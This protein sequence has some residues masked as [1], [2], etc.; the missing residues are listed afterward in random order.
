MK[1][2][3]KIICL[4][5]KNK[6]ISVVIPIFNC[7]DSILFVIRSIQNQ[8]MFEIEIILV[9]DHS[10]DDSL[11]IIRNIQKEDNRIIIINNKKNKG[12]FYSRSIGVLESKGEYI[13]PLDND[14][15]VFDR[16]VF[17]IVYKEA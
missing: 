14:D 2:L 9:N 1:L 4:N 12:T 5:Y 6:K 17:D 8:N 13:F 10:S 16:D 11:K 15:M 3:I 7:Q